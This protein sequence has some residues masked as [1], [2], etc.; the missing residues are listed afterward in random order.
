LG[1][2]PADVLFFPNIL[3]DHLRTN[4]TQPTFKV[5]RLSVKFHVVEN[6]HNRG[7]A[8]L[9]FFILRFFWELWVKGRQ[10]ACLNF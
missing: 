3:R 10:D 7:F 6:E 9:A 1:L 4:N 8:A 2:R 5:S